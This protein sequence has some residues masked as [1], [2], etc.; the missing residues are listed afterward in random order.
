LGRHWRGWKNKS[1]FQPPSLAGGC[2]DW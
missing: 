1:V 2:Q